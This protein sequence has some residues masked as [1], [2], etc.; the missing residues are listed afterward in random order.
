MAGRKRDRAVQ[1]RDGARAAPPRSWSIGELAR[2]AGLQPSAIRYYESAGLLPEPCRFNG[3]RVYDTSALEWLGVVRLAQRAGFSI[4]EIRELLHGFGRDTPAS[5]RWR[6]LASRKLEE[7][8]RRVEEARAME[9]VLERL[10]QC[11][12][13][14]L[15]D[16]GRAAEGDGVSGLETAAP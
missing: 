10:I 1:E 2:R 16:C 8:R 9:E 12:C 15:Q 3:R 5:K 14:T 7:V 13:P 4:S 11:D 6:S